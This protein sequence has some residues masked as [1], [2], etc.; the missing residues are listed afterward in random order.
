SVFA[1]GGLETV[2]IAAAES[3]D[4]VRGVAKAVKTTMWRIAIVYVGSMLVIVTLLPYLTGM[5]GLI[6]LAAAAILGGLFLY[7]TLQLKARSDV[8]LPMRTFSFSITYLAL[9]F[10]ALLVDHYFTIRIG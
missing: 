4:P 6:Y 3:E 10:A 5:S 2:T 1:Y 8:R 7:R 9:L